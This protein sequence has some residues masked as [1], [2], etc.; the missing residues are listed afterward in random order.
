MKNKVTSL[1]IAKVWVG[2]DG[3]R[4]TEIFCVLNNTLFY[5]FYNH[6]PSTWRANYGSETAIDEDYDIEID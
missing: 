2:P 3:M 5:D 4:G 6:N 1:G